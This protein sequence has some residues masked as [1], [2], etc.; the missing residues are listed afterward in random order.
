[1]LAGAQSRDQVGD[2]CELLL[3]VALIIL[4]P[5]EDVL[6]VVPPAAET[7]VMS[8]ACVM[9]G[10]PPLVAID[11]GVDALARPPERGSPFVEQAP[12]FRR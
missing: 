9:H 2:V 1:V 3:E 11:E 8:S 5:L 10:S 4:E 6:S 12:A 7:A